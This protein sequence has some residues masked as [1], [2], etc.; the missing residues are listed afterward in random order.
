MAQG[1]MN[2]EPMRL[3]LIRTGLLDECFSG[4][5]SVYIEVNV[6]C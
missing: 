5:V 6:L 3:E 2:G 4:F 1:H